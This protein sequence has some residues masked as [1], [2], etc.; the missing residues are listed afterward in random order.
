M[1]DLNLNRVNYILT[2]Y[3]VF[4]FFLIVDIYFK[5]KF[6]CRDHV[7]QYLLKAQNRK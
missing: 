7:V 2:Q 3:A 4:N 6:Y 5:V 1:Y